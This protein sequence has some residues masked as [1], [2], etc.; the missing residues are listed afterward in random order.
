MAITRMT[1]E[2]DDGTGQ[3]GS[4][5][6]NAWKQTLY[7]QIDAADLTVGASANTPWQ[8]I[9]YDANNFRLDSIAGPVFACTVLR[10]RWR[11]IG[12]NLVVWSFAANPITIQQAATYV[13]VLNLPFQIPHGANRGRVGYTVYTDVC[14]YPNT[15]TTM[16]FFRLGGF[17]QAGSGYW[18]YS[19]DMTI[20]SP[21]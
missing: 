11:R 7:D 12:T 16:G 1:L 14:W 10:N 13:L 2:D 9:P 20:W 6:D 5:F 19:G 21:A 18:L 8:P 17:W 4:V 3:V 15:A